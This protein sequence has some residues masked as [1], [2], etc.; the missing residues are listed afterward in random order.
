MDDLPDLSKLDKES[1]LFTPE[2]LGGFW[3]AKETNRRD[4]FSKRFRRVVK[5]HFKLN[6]WI[7]IYLIKKKLLK[8]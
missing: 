4:H 1:F 2:K 7:Y 6:K 5:E 3:D 8:Y